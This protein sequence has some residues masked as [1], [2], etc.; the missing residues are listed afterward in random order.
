MRLP[1][2]LLLSIAV[3]VLWGLWGALTEIPEKWLYPPFPPTLGYV[4]WSLTMIPVTVIA[5]LKIKWKTN[6]DA[7]VD[8]LWLR[9]RILGRG[10]AAHSILGAEARASL[11]DLPHCLPLACGHHRPFLDDSARTHLSPCTFRDTVV[12]PSDFSRLS[13]VAVRQ[14]CAWQPLAGGYDRNLFH[15]GSAGLLS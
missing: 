8:L 11:P 4:V 9:G 13:A 15:V 6:L 10:R 1:K 14:P 2:W 5:M 3:P 7:A 12:S